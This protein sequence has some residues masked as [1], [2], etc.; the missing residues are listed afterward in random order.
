MIAFVGV[1][2]LGDSSMRISML[3]A[4]VFPLIA[5]LFELNQFSSSL[6]ILI[7]TLEFKRMSQS[8]LSP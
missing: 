8:C 7:K 3:S 4:N 6:S 1:G 2:Y 5:G